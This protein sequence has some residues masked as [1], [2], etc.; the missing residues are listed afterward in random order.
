MNLGHP[1]SQVRA[2]DELLSGNDWPSP[3]PTYEEETRRFDEEFQRR[4]R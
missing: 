2:P 3:Y 4:K 1:P